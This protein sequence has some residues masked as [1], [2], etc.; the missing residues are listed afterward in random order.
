MRIGA[1]ITG[2]LRKE[3]EAE[4]RATAQALRRGVTKAGREVQAQL[5]NQVKQAGFKDGGRS[6]ANAWRLGVYPAAGQAPDTFKPASLVY[7]QA[8]KI[9]EAFDSGASITAK[10]GRYL[11]FPTGYNAIAGR[12]N[13]GSRG[14]LRVTPDQMKAARK[15]AFILRS[16]S[17]PEVLLWCL[18]VRAASGYSRTGRRSRRLRLFVGPNN[19]E[20]LTGKRKGQQ[21]AAKE[22]LSQ[23]FVPMFILVRRV[24]LRKRLNVQQV[25]AQAPGILARS[26]VAELRGISR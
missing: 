8:P 7:T 14:G 1:F 6:I 11:A 19:A 2:S 17:N 10:S 15:E 3:M 9:V 24:T 25:R 16:K 20:V 26:L 23:G 4:V 12:R 21:A 13:A 22:V 5:R 18:R